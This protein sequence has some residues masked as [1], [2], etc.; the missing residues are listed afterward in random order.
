MYF[1]FFI[2]PGWRKR[3]AVQPQTMDSE[4]PCYY[5]TIPPESQCSKGYFSG[6]SRGCRKNREKFGVFL[7]LLCVFPKNQVC[8]F[9]KFASP[10][11][12]FM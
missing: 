8:N 7:L 3:S 6:F 5:F 11:K 9:H 10:L 4:F 1:L 2:L 12:F